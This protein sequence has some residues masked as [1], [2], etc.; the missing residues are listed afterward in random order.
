MC[1]ASPGKIM[2]IK[3]NKALV[4]FGG[5][6]REVLADLAP[7]AKKGDYVL[8]HAGFVMKILEKKDALERLE[9]FKE[10]ENPAPKARKPGKKR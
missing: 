2:S 9:F 6:E 8:V 10:I 1:I 7:N 4:D 3:G 5:V